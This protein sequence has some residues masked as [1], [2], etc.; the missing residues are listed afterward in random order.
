M[1]QA[2]GYTLMEMMVVVAIVGILLLVAVPSYQSY[3]ESGRRAVAGACLIELSQF[4]ER[5]YTTSMA[6]NL[7]NGQATALPSTNCQVTLA[8]NYSFALQTTATTFLLTATPAGTSSCGALTINQAGQ[9]S[10][11]GD[12][13]AAA[14]KKCWE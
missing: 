2:K 9:R 13:S 10:A 4:M 14:I 11:N 8:S 12:S 1:K 3:V 7:H 6:Y 5:V